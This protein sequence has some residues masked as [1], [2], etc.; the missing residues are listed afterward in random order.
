M[1]ALGSQTA[2]DLFPV[3]Y[4]IKSELLTG[5]FQAFHGP[6]PT[7]S[8]LLPAPTQNSARPWLL[9]VAQASSGLATYA[10]ARGPS[11]KGPPFTGA[12]AAQL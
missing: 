9:T 5:A 12:T 11:P 2:V 8:C 1:C 6:A 10:P 7:K 3:H 4:G